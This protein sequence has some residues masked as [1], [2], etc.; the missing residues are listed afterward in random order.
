[1]HPRSIVRLANV[2]YNDADLKIVNMDK[3][4]TK[5]TSTHKAIDELLSQIID[6]WYHRISPH[7]VTHRQ[8]LASDSK[9]QD[10]EE[11]LKFFHDRTGHRI[12]FNKDELDFTYGLRCQRENE[13]SIIEISVNNKVKDFDYKDF[14][15]RLVSHYK[16]MGNRKVPSP[17]Q[18]KS[19]SYQEIFQLEPN[20]EETFSVES[21]DQK[22]DIMRLSFRVGDRFTEKLASHPVAG[23]KLIE[24][25]C[26]SPFRKVYATVYRRVSR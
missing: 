22:A 25:Y 6:E 9:G 10:R 15:R 13:Y 16:K 1:M 8:T 5:V 7:Y 18:L 4:K 20:L 2:V 12:K 19:Y 23:K 21:R 24:E 17:F 26:V 11:E 3:T 14:Q